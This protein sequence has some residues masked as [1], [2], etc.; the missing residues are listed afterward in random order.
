MRWL[1][2]LVLLPAFAGGAA[3]ADVKATS[4]ID[5]VTVYP[6]GAEIVR[7][8]TV[9]LERG[10]HAIPIAQQVKS[11]DRCDNEQREDG[12]HRLALGPQ[13]GNGAG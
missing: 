6:S 13:G 2:V 11:H 5:S 12:Q 8:L 4:H 10:D 1:L 7:V 9:P 3:A